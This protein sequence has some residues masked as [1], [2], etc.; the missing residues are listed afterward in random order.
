MEADMKRMDSKWKELERI[1]EDRVGWRI[2]VVG[3]CSST[4]VNR[5]IHLSPDVLVDS[6][7][8]KRHS[9]KVMRVINMA[10]KALEGDSKSLY[11][12]LALLGAKHAAINNMKIEY[13]KV[14]YAIYIPYN[15]VNYK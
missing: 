11:E 13:F 7:D 10:V 14:S 6:P 4:R 2:L 3:L 15:V 1:V 9:A 12:E 5:R 8:C